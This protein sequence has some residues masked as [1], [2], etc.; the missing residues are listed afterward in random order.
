MQVLVSLAHAAVTAA[1][2]KEGKRLSKE[3]MKGELE[4]GAEIVKAVFSFVVPLSQLAQRADGISFCRELP[5][6]DVVIPVLL[7]KGVHKLKESCFLTPGPS[8]PR[9][10]NAR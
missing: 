3:R 4:E 1:A 10:L 5:S 7:E 8:P 6:Y 9:T 2:L